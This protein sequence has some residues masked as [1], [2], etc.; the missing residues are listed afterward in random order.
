[1]KKLFPLLLFLLTAVSTTAQETYFQENG[2]WY[3]VLTSAAQKSYDASHNEVAVTRPQVSPGKYADG[4]KIYVPSTVIH[5]SKTYT[6]TYIDNRAFA[7]TKLD[8]LA[9]PP[10]ILKSDERILEGAKLKH[11]HTPENLEVLPAY[12]IWTGEIDE[13]WLSPKVK[14]IGTYAFA[15]TTI[16]RVHGLAQTK[17]ER[18]GSES[19]F[20]LAACFYNYIYLPVADQAAYINDLSAL[21]PTVRII[22]A[23]ALNGGNIGAP[24]LPISNYTIPA[25][26]EKIGDYNFEVSDR[27]TV[28]H[29]T[30]FILGINAFGTQ[31]T[32]KIFVPTDCSVSYKTATNWSSYSNKFREEVKVGSTGYTTYYLENENFKVPA[33]CTAYI[34][35]G[36]TPS[37]SIT[38]PDQAVVK[39]FGAGKIIPKKTGFILQSTPNTTVEYQ[40]NVTGTEENVTGN[41]LVGTATEQEI[42][43]AGYKYYILSNSGDQG[44]GFY[45]QGTRQGASIKLKPHR[46]GLRLDESIARAKSFIIDFDAARREAE[47]TGIRRVHPESRQNDNAIYDLQGRRVT[48]PTHGIYIINGKESN[49]QINAC[50][51]EKEIHNSRN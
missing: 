14:E 31:A 18:F 30:P 28:P 19:Y 32:L 24:Q 51:N 13:L 7:G 22:G 35:T 20:G 15:L 38:T 9:L 49:N 12:F 34:I 46:A 27:V 47:T 44:L 33:G 11:F 4:S 23:M 43:G 3:R 8:S 5:D 29:T 37:G 10:S 1:M 26:M 6:V 41:L 39:A 17:L 45:K 42:S 50:D 40:A 2:I 25:I 48:N 21:P 16:K 36:V